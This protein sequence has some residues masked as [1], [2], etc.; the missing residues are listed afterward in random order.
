M[1]IQTPVRGDR[2]QSKQTGQYYVVLNTKG[3]NMRLSSESHDATFWRP[4]FG[5]EEV[6][7]IVIPSVDSR[8]ESLY[9][10]PEKQEMVIVG[11]NKDG[12]FYYSY[13]DPLYTKGL[14]RKSDYEGI[15]DLTQVIVE[16]NLYLIGLL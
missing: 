3:Q 2:L 4:I 7:E 6:F 14:I 16:H 10:S 5:Y 1:I 8:A 13:V 15:K 12:D 11:I 9:Y